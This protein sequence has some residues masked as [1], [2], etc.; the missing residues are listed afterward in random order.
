ML[1]ITDDY[2]HFDS[3]IIIHIN[4]VFMILNQLG[5]GPKNGFHI[6]DKFVTWDD[7]LPDDNKNFEA[8]KS[9][10]HL[11]V[12]LLFDPPI[13]SIVMEAMK[14]MINE[15]EWRL[16]IEAEQTGEEENQNG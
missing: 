4:S 2:T 1:G 12:K 10:M 16:N 9:Y 14:Q 13:S 7:F 8:V 6:T 15:L 5:I 3:D 11:K